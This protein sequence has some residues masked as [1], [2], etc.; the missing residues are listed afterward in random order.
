[1]IPNKKNETFNGKHPYITQPHAKKDKHPPSTH[2]S[3]K[4][5]PLDVGK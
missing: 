3:Q 2:T 5:T 4:K 1:M